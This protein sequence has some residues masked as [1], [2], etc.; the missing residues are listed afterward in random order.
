MAAA[1]AI[2]EM[3]SSSTLLEKDRRSLH[4][5]RL[6]G[7]PAF[8]IGL[9]SLLLSLL[10]LMARQREIPEIRAFGR[11]VLGALP[12]G[13]DFLGGLFHFQFSPPFVTLATGLGLALLIWGWAELLGASRIKRELIAAEE[14]KRQ[15]QIAHEMESEDARHDRGPAAEARR[16]EQLASEMKA[17]EASPSPAQDPHR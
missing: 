10:G 1:R 5:H 9:V 17:E 7:Q 8:W 15:Q 14:L 2:P 4:G 13:T 12:G 6:R 3:N 11:R 16:R